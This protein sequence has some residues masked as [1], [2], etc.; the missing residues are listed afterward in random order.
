MLPNLNFSLLRR[1]V[2]ETPSAAAN[3]TLQPV[4]QPMPPPVQQSSQAALQAPVQTGKTELEANFARIAAQ[5]TLLWGY[6]EMDTFF[7]KL[8][9][10]DRGNRAGFPRPVMEDL[11]FLASLHQCAHPQNPT[12]PYVNRGLSEDIYYRNR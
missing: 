6:P 11:M 1:P 9:I 7:S 2:R 3:S 4:S 5:I 8:W 12:A 10:D